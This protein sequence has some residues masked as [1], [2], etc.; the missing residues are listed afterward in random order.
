MNK[1][2]VRLMIKIDLKEE[3]CRLLGEKELSELEKLIEGDEFSN[4]RELLEEWGVDVKRL[5]REHPY[6]S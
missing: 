5:Y 2:S 6:F 1:K 4:I 3:R